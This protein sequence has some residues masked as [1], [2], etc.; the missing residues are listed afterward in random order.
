MSK[1]PGD[2][3]CEHAS[4]RWAMG[5]GKSIETMT[6]T[7]FGRCFEPASS[8]SDGMLIRRETCSNGSHQN[9]YRVTRG[10]AHTAPYGE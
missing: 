7:L 8:L 1:L 5:R 6:R 9:L 3:E 2:E 10:G 4:R